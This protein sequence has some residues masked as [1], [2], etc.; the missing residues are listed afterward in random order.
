[1]T[2][3][4]NAG[5]RVGM[6]VGGRKGEGV[7]VGCGEGV[8]VG[9]GEGGSN[10]AVGCDGEVGVGVGEGGREVGVGCGDGMNVRVGKGD[11]AVCVDR[12]RLAEQ[13]TASATKVRYI[14][15]PIQK[16]CL[17]LVIKKSDIVYI[18][19]SWPSNHVNKHP[20]DRQQDH[21]AGFQR[22][23]IDGSL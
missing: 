3:E 12:D 18:T 20:F 13:P 4:D 2:P 23:G 6:A 15:N 9:V 1:M 16:N 17:L 10:V 8:K 7:G 5:G 22:E 14:V 11:A 19:V 21:F